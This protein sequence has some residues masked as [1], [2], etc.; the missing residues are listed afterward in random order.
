MKSFPLF[1]ALKYM[2]P[3]R[4]FASVITIITVLGVTLGVAILMIVLAVMTGFGDVWKEKILSFKPHI[5]ISSRYTDSIPNPDEICDL[6]LKDE[7]VTACMPTIA[8]QV[9]VK[10]RDDVEPVVAQVI[11]V[12]PLRSQMFDKVKDKIKVGEFN[13]A[14]DSAVIGIDMALY[15][16]GVNAPGQRLLCYTALNLKSA[17]ELYFPEELY[18]TGIYD[19]GMRDFDDGLIITSLG[20]ARDITGLEE[21][22]QTI[23]VQL[24]EPELAFVAQER[25]AAQLGPL[26]VVNNWQEN[27][28]V[29]FE[30]LRTE[31]T[32]MF[33]LLFF[34]AIVAAFCVTNTL[35][36]ITI[37]KTPEIGLLKALGFSNRQLKQAFIING[38]LQCIIGIVL[39]VAL[40]WLVLINLQNI[41]AALSSVGI[42][43]F[44]K[45]I[46]GLG[47][48]PYRIV[49]SDVLATVGAVFVL[50]SLASFLPA[51]RAASLDPIK[52]INQE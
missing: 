35:I 27:D 2:L 38:Q 51:W 37:Q 52:A 34:I 20:M 3:K 6:V 7:A 40:G 1:L 28:Q 17:N 22:C 19:M 45:E 4:S 48:I 36:V 30:A 15:R 39:G 31:K 32:M 50:C 21:G 33:I 23:Q 14:E 12:D 13:V 47:A 46:Y 16:L 18:V 26:F 5:T 24:K 41:V 42:E 11:G 25:I 43:V 29:L 49:A 8:S 10:Y 44:P 9:M